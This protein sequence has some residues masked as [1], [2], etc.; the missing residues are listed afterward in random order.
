MFS[1]VFKKEQKNIINNEEAINNNSL[2]KNL[3][4]R[5]KNV[6]GVIEYEI[7]M[8]DTKTGHFPYALKHYVFKIAQDISI[9]YKE[10][11][12]KNDNLECSDF[13][14]I[15]CFGIEK[16]TTEFKCRHINH[17]YEY[18]FGFK[19]WHKTSEGHSVS[20]KAYIYCSSSFIYNTEYPEG[21][22]ELL[23]QIQKDMQ[24]AIENAKG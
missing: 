14:V 8:T 20:D 10:I 24:E 6:D 4:V 18:T 9:S 3:E 17:W 16:V 12:L 11:N 1:K 23:H 13:E 15:P 21:I 5:S 2:Y 7:T 22:E 19:F